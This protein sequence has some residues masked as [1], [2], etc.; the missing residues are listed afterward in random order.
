MI[1]S[2]DFET[3]S[4]EDKVN[5]LGKD[6]LYLMCR[7]N[8][9]FNILLYSIYGMYAEAWFFKKSN[10]LDSIDIINDEK[11]VELYLEKMRIPIP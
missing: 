1:R 6:G 8:Q 10:M 11:A 3:L 5:V 9:L 2:I 7:Q 4:L